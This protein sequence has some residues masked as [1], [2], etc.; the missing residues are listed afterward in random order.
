MSAHIQLAGVGVNFPIFDGRTRSLKQQLIASTIG[1]R[2]GIGARQQASIRA[3][4]GIDLELGHGT[5]VGLVGHNGAGKST[6]LRVLAGIYE[7]HE[8]AVSVSGKVAPLFD[9]GLGM[10][11]QGTGHENIVLRGLYLGLT[12]REI[13]ARDAEIAAFSELGSFL[14][15]PLYTYSAGMHARL[16]F[17]ISTSIDAE[18]LLLDEGIGT[19]DAAFL[20]KAR[21]RIAGL[22]GRASIV[23]IASHRESILRE[24]CT[25][26]VLLEHGRI[27]AHGSVNEIVHLMHDKGQALR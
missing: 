6:L 27:L 5:R 14:D 2:I 15:M 10:D 13:Q 4:D 26:L 21:A 25:H 3:L 12:R 23:V 17:S 16:A 11:M 9:I 19:S 24:L 22:A 7:P 1:G 18:I 20:A 8:G